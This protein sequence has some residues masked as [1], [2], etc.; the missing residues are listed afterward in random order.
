MKVSIS[1]DTLIKFNS[2]GGWLMGV[3]LVVVIGYFAKHTNEP[4][5]GG[6]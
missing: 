4:H 3:G 5:Q 6:L 1:H 2:P